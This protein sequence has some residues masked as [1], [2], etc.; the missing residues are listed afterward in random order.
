MKQWNLLRL[1]GERNLKQEDLA[2]LLNITTDSFGNK[3][4]GQTQFQM[5]EM[6]TLSRYFELPLEQIFLP[7]DFGITEVG[8]VESW[9]CQ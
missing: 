7:R 8:E 3:E 1:R 2:K 9:N 6:F 5:D 4:R